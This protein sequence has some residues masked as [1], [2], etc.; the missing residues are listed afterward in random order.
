MKLHELDK[1][2]ETPF[3]WTDF[4][5]LTTQERITLAEALLFDNT[6]FESNDSDKL[7]EFRDIQQSG[8]MPVTNK[9]YIVAMYGMMNNAVQS[10]QHPEVMTVLD[11]TPDGWSVQRAN[12][13]HSTFP[14]N[15][16]S[17]RVATLL[18]FFESIDK[19]DA[20]TTMMVLKYDL[21]VVKQADI[22]GIDQLSQQKV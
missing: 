15:H 12:G 21:R 7:A 13:T 20:F 10:F 14:D 2:Y 16:F 11:K 18:M 8:D 17:T 5:G 1:K 22:I 9:K 3:Q 6:L 19:Y 4:P